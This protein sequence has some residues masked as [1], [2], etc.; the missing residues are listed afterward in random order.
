[1]PLSMIFATLKNKRFIVSL[2][3]QISPLGMNLVNETFVSLQIAPDETKLQGIEAPSSGEAS[4]KIPKHK[5]N[6]V[7][8]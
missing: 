4:L 3:N 7:T 6:T 2:Q 5:W 8:Q 1:M